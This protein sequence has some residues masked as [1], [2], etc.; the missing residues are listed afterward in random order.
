MRK[1]DSL[2]QGKLFDRTALITGASGGMMGMGYQREVFLQSMRDSTINRHDRSYIRHISKDLLNSISFSVVSQDLFLPWRTFEHN[3]QEFVRDRGYAFEQQLNEN[4][5]HILEKTVG[6]YRAPEQQAL[7]PMM[8]LTP[9][10]VNDAR[11]LIISPQGATFMMMAPLA[12]DKPGAVEVDAVD[13]QW[14]FA[15]NRPDDLLWTSALRMNASYPYVLPN[16]HLP[17]T[18][19]IE[20][21]DAGFR[22][23]TGLLSATRFIQVFKDWLLEH[24]GGV[25]IVQVS[26]F[27]R[28]EPI[29]PS[30]YQGLIKSIFNPL[31]IAGQLLSLQ[32]YEHDNSLGFIYELLGKEN[33]ELIRFFYAPT[34]EDSRRTSI[35]F[36]I[37]ERERN[38]VLEAIE[39]P[40]NREKLGKLMQLLDASGDPGPL[41]A[42]QTSP[43]D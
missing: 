42:H 15:Q 9:A 33:F 39:Y 29:D 16:V 8:Y 17:T 21:L 19:G 32:E 31:G 10:I 30:D 20:V 41:E 28:I 1:A 12:V 4:T 18:P 37:T 25:V 23:N 22:D 5:Q 43:T 38:S 24:T 13:Y 3:G 27:S 26:A 36:H 14:L 6:D 7:I 40:G 34:V 35:S 11:R 2:S